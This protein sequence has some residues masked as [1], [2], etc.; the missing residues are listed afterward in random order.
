M[1][2]RLSNKVKHNKINLLDLS[3]IDHAFKALIQKGVW[4]GAFDSI[5]LNLPALAGKIE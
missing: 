3:R 1:K 5:K 2:D 4:C